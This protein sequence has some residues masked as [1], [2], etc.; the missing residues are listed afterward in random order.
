MRVSLL[1][2]TFLLK[3]NHL[4]SGFSTITHNLQ[5]TSPSASHR[6]N[7]AAA[8]SLPLED[9]VPVPVVQ[10]QEESNVGVLLL[11]LGGPEK[12]EDVEG[13]KVTANE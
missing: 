2:F 4:C 11:N 10:T 9:F 13:M 12:T 8:T 5:I 3:A 1:S 6:T 7:L